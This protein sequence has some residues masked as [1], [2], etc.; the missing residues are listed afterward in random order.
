MTKEEENMDIEVFKKKAEFF[1]LNYTPVHITLKD[2]NFLNGHV[3]GVGSPDFFM[4]EEFKEGEMPVFY[5][6]IYAIR[7]YKENNR[8]EENE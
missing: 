7:K 8:E 4:L 6:E 2:S 1:H 3:I 5:M